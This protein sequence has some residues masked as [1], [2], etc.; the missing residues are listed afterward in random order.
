MF[1]PRSHLVG[2]SRP[3]PSIRPPSFASMYRSAIYVNPIL[4]RTAI[5]REVPPD[6]VNTQLANCSVGLIPK[7]QCSGQAENLNNLV[8]ERV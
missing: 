2:N 7:R 1:M 8:P 3:H 4:C 5:R 6:V